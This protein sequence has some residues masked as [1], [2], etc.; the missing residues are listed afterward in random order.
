[1]SS[2]AAASLLFP[3]AGQRLWNLGQE[4]SRVFS[5]FLPFACGRAWILQEGSSSGE[6]FLWEGGI[7]FSPKYSLAVERGKVQAQIPPAQLCQNPVE[8]RKSRAGSQ[9]KPTASLR[10][11]STGIVLQVKVFNC[12]FE[13]SLK[14]D[15]PPF[16][17]AARP[18]PVPCVP[19]E[20]GEPGQ[21]CPSPCPRTQGTALGQLRVQGSS[22]GLGT[23]TGTLS[24]T[25]RAEYLLPK[26]HN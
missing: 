4:N 23:G 20:L 9:D 22:T 16:P 24:Y 18:G 26:V 3:T 7:V 19:T 25:R 17:T 13:D 10:N 21:G 5:S 8:G 12:F 15:S 11:Y 6:C 2:P 14:H 1:M